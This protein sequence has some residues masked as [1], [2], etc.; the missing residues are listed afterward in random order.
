MTFFARLNSRLQFLTLSWVRAPGHVSCFGSD[1]LWLPLSLISPL[2]ST[3]KSL[4]PGTS[5][6]CLLFIKY[7]VCSSQQHCNGAGIGILH[8]WKR[9]HW[10]GGSLPDVTQGAGRGA[11]TWLLPGPAAT[12]GKPSGSLGR[13][14][15]TLTAVLRQVTPKPRASRRLYS[16]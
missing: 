12:P 4:P 15:R 1:C 8:L 11:G 10:G 9:K 7:L 2:F 5:G 16:L 14:H 6:V 13:G 3:I